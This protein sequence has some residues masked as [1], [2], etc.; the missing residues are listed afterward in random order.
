MAIIPPRLYH[1]VDRHLRDADR[2]LRIA[3][4]RA[5]DASLGGNGSV[6]DGGPKAKGRVSR[7]TETMAVG[8]YA[9]EEGI[10]Q[11]K[12]WVSLRQEMADW[13]LHRETQIAPFWKAYYGHGLRMADAAASCHLSTQTAYDYRDRIVVNAALIA[14]GRGM[15]KAE[16]TEKEEE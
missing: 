3:L 2:L 10:R 12:A 6:M 5:Q 1:L 9:A 14:V 7:P 16:L 8:K 15:V 13:C 4:E 11:A